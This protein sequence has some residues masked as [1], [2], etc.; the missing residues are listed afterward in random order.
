MISI[1]H[2]YLHYSVL[3][4]ARN[5][6]IFLKVGISEYVTEN[7]IRYYCLFCFSFVCQYCRWQVVTRSVYHLIPWKFWSLC[8]KSCNMERL[9]K[10][11]LRESRHCKIVISLPAIEQNEIIHLSIV[12]NSRGNSR[13]GCLPVYSN[14]TSAENCRFVERHASREHKRAR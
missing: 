3:D 12:T 10:E 4:G 1:L 9:S 2:T 13:V 11:N 7:S 5:I 14:K 8:R 6:L